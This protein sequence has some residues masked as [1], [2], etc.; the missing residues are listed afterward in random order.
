MK[1][2]IKRHPESETGLDDAYGPGRL[3]RAVT[4]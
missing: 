1:G 3:A 4:C 2:A